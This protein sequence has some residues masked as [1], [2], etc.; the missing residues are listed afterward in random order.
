MADRPVAD[1]ARDLNRTVAA[2]RA[3]RNELRRQYAD[4]IQW[5]VAE[6]NCPH[7]GGM[8]PLWTPQAIV[9]ALQAWA[10]KHGRTPSRDDWR[11]A[12]RSNPAVETVDRVFGT[13]NHALEAA[14]LPT[15]IAGPQKHWTRD[16]IIE[17]IQAWARR[18]NEPPRKS[19]WYK[20]A[21]EHPNCET[22]CKE[23]GRWN[24]AIEE[25]GF[26]PRGKWGHRYTTAG[27]HRPLGGNVNGDRADTRASLTDEREAA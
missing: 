1:I 15:R 26:F 4:R 16:R 12:T 9:E 14:G 25:A 21:P 24:L 17:A 5:F 7:C 6:G 13:L 3:R 20:A 2:V 23:F 11:A 18:Y 10:S 22:V 19:D 8:P 27:L